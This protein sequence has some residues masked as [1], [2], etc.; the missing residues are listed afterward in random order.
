MEIAFQG[1]KPPP[2]K[3]QTITF[4]MRQAHQ[5]TTDKGRLTHKCNP[6]IPTQANLYRS[7]PSFINQPIKIIDS[8]QSKK[9]RTEET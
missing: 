4:L 3:I 9:E 7:L 5:T 6:K 2:A 1:W 8:N